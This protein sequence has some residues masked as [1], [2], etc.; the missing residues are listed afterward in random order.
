MGLTVKLHAALSCIAAIVTPE[1]RAHNQTQTDPETSTRTVARMV[2]IDRIQ[3][4]HRLFRSHRW[5]VP[6]AT[7][8]DELRCTRRTA[9]RL[10]DEMR[11]FLHAPL[12][13]DPGRKGWHYRPDERDQFEL[14]GM[15]LT[16]EELQSLTLLLHVIE[17]VGRGL[18]DQDLRPVA[19]QIDALLRVRGI[20]PGAFAERIRILPMAQRNLPGHV[21]QV[22]AEALLQHC[23]LAIRY[24]DYSGH[25]SKRILSPQNLVLYR[26]NWYL[27]AW[28]HR[29][30]ALRT[31]SLARIDNCQLTEGT[32]QAVPTARLEEEYA[33]GYGIFAGE[34]RH[35][36]VLRFL[37]RVAREISKQHWHPQQQTRWDGDCLLLSFPYAR[38][39]ELIGD[40]LRH[41]PDVV[42]EGPREL[43]EAVVQR[44]KAGIGVYG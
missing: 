19:R 15:W 33:R 38:P 23:R 31:F 5:P 20:E 17:S 36:A 18:L 8:A 3:Q 44:L 32:Y 22:T 1:K 25:T 26:D 42:V 13:Y 24:T 7:L 41:V 35:T 12:E 30:Q 2:K 21:F 43:K 6:I 37:P 4:L 11:D 16:A 28:C 34:P 39:D 40:I 14:P 9:R 27:D 10:I 29:K